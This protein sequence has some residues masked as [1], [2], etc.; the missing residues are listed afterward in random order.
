MNLKRRLR[1]LEQNV[2]PPD[3]Y[4]CELC[5]Y[6]PGSELEFEVSFANEP[7]VGPDV[8]PGC[9]RPLILRLSF[10]EPLRRVE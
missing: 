10:D 6:D 8:C 7:D 3:E 9:S 5:G 1:A 2:V 4:R